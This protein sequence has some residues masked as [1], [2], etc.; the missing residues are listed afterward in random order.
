MAVISK[1]ILYNVTR[2]LSFTQSV[3]LKNYV[4]CS[5]IGFSV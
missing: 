3:M 5:N 4:E 1:K 2:Q